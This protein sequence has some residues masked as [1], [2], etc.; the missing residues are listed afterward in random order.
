MRTSAN[1][2]NLFKLRKVDHLRAREKFNEKES[3]VEPRAN[4]SVYER[5]VRAGES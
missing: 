2:F 3:K 1:L 4:A 5:V